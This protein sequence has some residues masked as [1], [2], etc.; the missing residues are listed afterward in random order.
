MMYW[1]KSKSC[2]ASEGLLPQ[3][4]ILD[5]IQK[6][7]KAIFLE[8]SLQLEKVTFVTLKSRPTWY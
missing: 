4:L 8:E 7:Q 2:S 6:Q 3:A 1:N 5:L